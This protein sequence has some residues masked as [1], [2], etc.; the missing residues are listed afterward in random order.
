MDV[1]EEWKFMMGTYLRSVN[2]SQYLI[3]MHILCN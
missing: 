1:N 3:N 2:N